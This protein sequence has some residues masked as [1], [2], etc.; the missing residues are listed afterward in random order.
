VT[1]QH[2]LTPPPELLQKWWAETIDQ[3][4]ADAL[5]AACAAKWGA[6]QELEACCDW[7]QEFYKTE[8]WVKHDLEHFRSARRPKPLSLKQ[9]ALEAL[10]KSYVEM[11]CVDMEADLA[12][13]HAAIESLPD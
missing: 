13:I 6:D 11:W 12:V 5:F 9:Q 10:S 2:P 1:Q 3:P 7:F 8:S 4:Q